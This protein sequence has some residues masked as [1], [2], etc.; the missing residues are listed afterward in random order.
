MDDQVPTVSSPAFITELMTRTTCIKRIVQLDIDGTET[1]ELDWLAATDEFS[2]P[3]PDSNLRY[4]S[5]NG[6][7]WR[8]IRALLGMEMQCRSTLTY[9]PN[10]FYELMFETTTGRESAE[11]R[12]SFAAR[13]TQELMHIPDDQWIRHRNAN[14]GWVMVCDDGVVGVVCE[15]AEVGD[16]IWRSA[17]GQL[18]VVRKELE[19]SSQLIGS[20][21][22]YTGVGH[23]SM[24]MGIHRPDTL[25]C[26]IEYPTTCTNQGPRPE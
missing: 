7:W 16:L 10:S 11:G 20:A 22:I 6:P 3:L 4:G 17:F 21:W 13:A 12:A 8:L 25:C 18:L 5:T 24:D 15:G 19:V 2:I 9:A 26:V 23:T 14:G 1:G